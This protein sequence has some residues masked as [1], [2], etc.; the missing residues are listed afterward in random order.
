MTVVDNTVLVDFWAGEEKHRNKAKALFLKDS[1]WVAPDLWKYEFGNIMR[2][3]V[4]LGLFSEEL[5]D[6]AWSES[7]RMVK[8][9][10]EIDVLGVDQVAEQSGLKFYDASYVWLARSM[11]LPFYTRD[12][13]ILRTCSD[14]ACAMPDGE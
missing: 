11:G 9:V 4:R 7:L 1:H 14:V 6:L 8:T 3:Y 12:K 5:K 2:K 13:M 10:H